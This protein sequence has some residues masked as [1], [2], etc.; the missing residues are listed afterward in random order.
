[1]LDNSEANQYQDYLR[2]QALMNDNRLSD[3]SYLLGVDDDYLNSELDGERAVYNPD[4]DETDIQDGYEDELANIDQVIE[5]KC[6]I[7][8]PSYQ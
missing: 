1:M 3:V 7:Q 2:L 5:E 4:L 6:G 8:L